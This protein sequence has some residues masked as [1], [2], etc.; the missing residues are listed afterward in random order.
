M[1]FL[2]VQLRNEN[3][4]M[5]DKAETIQLTSILLNNL[6]QQTPGSKQLL[7][8]DDEMMSGYFLAKL[9][10]AFLNFAEKPDLVDKVKF[11]PNILINVTRVCNF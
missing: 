5:K 1:K 9:T 3:V 2:I 8:I 4:S 7:Q 6:T 10:E 11:I